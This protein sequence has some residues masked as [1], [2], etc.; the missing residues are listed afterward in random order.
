MNK[1]TND[2][3]HTRVSHGV[4]LAWVN[5][6][7]AVVVKTSDATMLFDPVGMEVPAD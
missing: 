4:A 2:I 5:S 6:Y 7:S 1:V 3:Y